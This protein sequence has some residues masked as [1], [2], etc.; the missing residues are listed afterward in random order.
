MFARQAATSG[1][2]TCYRHHDGEGWRAV[3][4]RQ[5]LEGTLA[6]AVHLL[7]EGVEPGERVS[8]LSENR[9]EWV[10]CDMAI[11]VVGGVTVPIYPTIPTRTARNILEHSGSRLVFVAGPE[12]QSRLAPQRALRMD[13]RVPGWMA[14]TPTPEAL[15]EVQAR[16]E[17]LRPPT[18]PPST[19]RRAG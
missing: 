19:T 8:I 1:E 13:T 3:S 14:E 17:A 9:L 10:I 16:T 11:Q 4:W 18:A 2:R 15:A 7:D 5:V 6:V 12:D